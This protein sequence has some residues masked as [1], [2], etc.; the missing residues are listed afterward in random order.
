MTDMDVRAMQ[1]EAASAAVHAEYV[2]ERAQAAYDGLL[3]R[4]AELEAKQEAE[5]EAMAEMLAEASRALSEAQDGHQAAR[6]HAEL[7]DAGSVTVMNGQ[8]VTA[9]AEAATA[10]GGA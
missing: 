3:A 8:Q 10:E 2:L 7:L 4:E 6:D 9:E 5:R 1:R